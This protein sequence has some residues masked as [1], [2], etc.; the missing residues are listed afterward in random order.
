MDILDKTMFP[1]DSV[2]D[3][4]EKMIGDVQNAVKDGQT[5]FCHAPTGIGKTAAVLAPALLYALESGKTVFFV[6]PKHSQH[7]IAIE[8]LSLM[9]KKHKK[10]IHCVD[11]IGKQW[12]CLYPAAAEL[13]PSEFNFFCKS[14]KDNRTCRFRNHTYF[15]KTNGLTDDAKRAVARLK[16]RGPMHSENA[17]VL[18]KDLG[19]CPY[20]V[21]TAAAKGA[22]VIICDYYH[23][24]HPDIRK[25]LLSKAGKS[26]EDCVIIVDEAHNLPDRIRSLMSTNLSEYYLTQAA[27]EAKAIG[28]ERIESDLQ[29]ILDSVVALGQKM[30]SFEEVCVKEKFVSLVEKECMAAIETFAEELEALSEEVL[31]LPNRTRSFALSVAAFLSEWAEKREEEAYVRVLDAYNSQSGKRYRLSLKC[32][33]SGI[34]T[35]EVLA[36]AHSTILMSGTLLPLEM[37]AKI[38]GANSPI[39][40]QYDNPFPKENRLVLSIKGVTTKY[41]NRGDAMWQKYA[42]KISRMIKLIPGNSAVFV[43]SYGILEQIEPRVNCGIKEK[44]IERQG[45]GKNERFKVHERMAELGERGG[46]VLFAVQAGSFSEGMD[47]PGRMLDA[48]FIVGVPLERP[49]LEVESLI[50]YYDVQFSKGW[51]YGYTYPAMNK[52]LQ[53]AGRCIRSETD[54]GAIILMDDRFMWKNYQKCMPKDFRPISTEIPE[55]YLEK[56]FGKKEE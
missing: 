45:M 9:S 54:R 22:N 21:S 53:A 19:V 46:A 47:F 37:Y 49:T 24:F 5:L 17:F 26:L 16:E 4:Q 1:F 7:K 27:R 40:K 28:H 39:L 18:C 29:S 20:E 55:L 48:C 25:T 35:S 31:E 36:R 50:K 14:H 56:F 11:M 6:T 2:R 44:I 38:L 15:G 3:E 41:S 43:P 23:M 33:D 10:K 34:Y 12:T 8:T 42:D 32:L 30:N 52:S 13:N 51:D